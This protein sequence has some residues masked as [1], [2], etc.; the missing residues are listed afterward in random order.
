MAPPKK[1]SGKQKTAKSQA[2]AAGG[3]PFAIIE[4]MD[5]NPA[6]PEEFDASPHD[7]DEFYFKAD[8][9]ASDV[10]ILFFH[11]TSHP[12]KRNLTLPTLLRASITIRSQSAF[13]SRFSI[14]SILTALPSTG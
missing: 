13:F 6:S 2:A 7:E 4:R 12:N 10:C 3:N 1:G 8:D 11:F 14:L 9:E 5:G